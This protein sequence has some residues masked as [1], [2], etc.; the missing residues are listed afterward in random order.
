MAPMEEEE[1]L[2]ECEQHDAV[3]DGEGEHVTS[4]HAIDHRDEWTSQTNGAGEEH[5]KEPG[6]RDGEYQNDFLSFPVARQS[7][8]DAGQRQE[9]GS[10]KDGLGW[11][12]RLN[13][14]KQ[15]AIK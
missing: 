13:K 14:S 6:G 5:E 12:V 15:R 2:R 8:R 4:D 3:N 7:T 11:I 1:C 9:I 10:Q